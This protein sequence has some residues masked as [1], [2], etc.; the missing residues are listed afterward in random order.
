MVFAAAI[1]AACGRH[2]RSV[3]KDT[4]KRQPVIV[5]PTTGEDKKRNDD[6]TTWGAIAHDGQ[7]WVR[8][9]SRPYDIEKGLD[10]RHLALWA[11]HGRY[12]DARRGWRWQRPRLFATC[13]DLFTQTI[14]VPYLIPMLENAGAV[15]FTPRERDWQT[16]EVI[17]DND[18][19]YHGISYFEFSDDNRWMT[20]DSAGFA[21]HSG[22]YHDGE[23]PFNAGT[24]R[25]VKAT[26]KEN[27]LSIVSY[28]P[29]IPEEGRY[30]VYVSYQTLPN[31]VDDASYTVWHKGVATQF[32]VNQRMGGGTW[33]YLGTFDFDRGSSEYNRVVLT[34]LSS[35]RRG[36][37]TADAVRFGGGMGNIERGGATSGLPRCLEGARYYAQWAGMPYDVYGGYGGEDDYKDDINTR[38]LMTN[39]L[40]GGSCFMPTV[41][42]L[43][44]PLELSLA[45]HSDAGFAPDGVSLVGT[46]A[47][48]TTDYHDG[49]LNSGLPRSTSTKFATALLNNT[50]K[51]LRSKYGRWAMRELYDRNY[52]ETRLPEVPSAI[53]ETMSHQNFP[54]MRLGQDP[55]FRFT[56][57]R[58]VY[59]TILRYVSE[60]HGVESVVQPLAPTDFSVQLN[61]NVATLSWSPVADEQERSAWPTG[62]IVYTRHGSAGFDNGIPVS[63]NTFSL[64]LTPNV[65]YSFRVAATNSGGRSFPS[66]E[67]C[68]MYDTLAT[69]TVL[70]VNGF[71][72]LS[73][74]AVVDNS[75]AQGFDLN[76][77]AGVALGPTFGWCGA[78]QCFDRSQMGSEETTGLGYSG[79]ELSGR[80]IAGNNMD[81]VRTH[82]EAIRQAG[83][84][85]IASASSYA[86]D[87]GRLSLDAYAAIDLALGL[88]RND[89]HSLVYYK[90]FSPAMQSSLRSYAARGGA[91]LVSGAYVGS[92]MVADCERAFLAN[93]LKCSLG[94]SYSAACDTIRGLGTT[95]TYHNSI[96]A[97]HYAALTA[98]NLTTRQPAYAAMLY[99]DGSSACVA[100]RG[101][102]YR[103]LTLGFPFECIK[104]AKKR[105]AIMRGLINFLLK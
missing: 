8:N 82:A 89:G 49:R 73:S 88:E 69:K 14:V 99:A 55:N 25:M 9:L 7:P 71:H 96:N 30:A 12:Y 47:I 53:L 72:R 31:S 92:D 19:P 84:Y 98:D 45:V 16:N 44:V 42:G 102:D 77:D 38:S 51:D 54:D 3:T 2:T 50:T 15:V 17:V 81:C 100:Y 10:G 39:R 24:A 87:R 37:V 63:C 13:E 1:V 57:A 64:R 65:L 48:N 6:K 18:T 11:S 28:Q 79:D 32:H 40:G 58:S 41:S 70:I 61:G 29:T 36:V 76:T 27:K 56:L 103:A 91:L 80:L 101:S 59:K 86:I 68:A 67:L 95:F 33:V 94:G 46:L 34:N 35:N 78:Q 26:S 97:R 4:T 104:D 66:E 5:T 60:M 105:Y 52:S 93:T 85:N 20:T 62:Y 75:A 23:N 43:G 90:T 74:P 83:H 21:L 22:C